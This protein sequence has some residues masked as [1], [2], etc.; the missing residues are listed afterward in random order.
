M[1]VVIGEAASKRV[2]SQ[3]R[4]TYSSVK[5]VIGRTRKEAKEAGVG[6]GALNVDKVH[7]SWVLC[8]IALR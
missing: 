6:L 8:G 7:Q 5:R 1:R 4:S 3:P 2:A